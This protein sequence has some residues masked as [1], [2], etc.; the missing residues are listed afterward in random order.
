MRPSPLTVSALNEYVRRSLAGDPMLQGIAI[1]GEISNFKRHASGHLYFTLKDAT[2]RIG[3]VMFRQYAQMLRFVPADGMHVMLSGS[4]SLY[5][6]SGAYQFYGEAMSEQ[7]AGVLY[8]SFMKIKDQLQREGLFDVS[9]KQALPLMP[10]GIGIVTASGGAVLHDI[11]TTA[12]R[13]FPGI[14]LFLRPA[15]VQGPLAAADLAMGLEEIASLEQVEVIII[16]RGGGSLEDLW[17]FNEEVLVRAVAACRKPVISAVGHETDVTLCD[18]AADVRA[19]TPTAAAELA[20]PSRIELSQRVDYLRTAL[21]IQATRR[22]SELQSRL[23]GLHDALMVNNPEHRIQAALLQ[24]TAL[25]TRVFHLAESAL[26][27]KFAVTLSLIARFEASGPRQTLQR[28]YVIATDKGKPV[29]SVKQVRENLDLQFYDGLVT[30]RVTSIK[31]E[32]QP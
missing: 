27:H 23:Q 19:A 13:R 7:G 26:Q 3:C 29:Q 15:Q 30:A 11:V 14:Q 32:A 17:A 24:L 6:A 25:Q 4:V 22:L 12:R 5:T 16:G 2:A 31:Q 18:F 28:G 9:L 8:E 21:T 20:V 1:Q 10:R